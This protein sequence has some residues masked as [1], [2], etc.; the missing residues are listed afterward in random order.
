MA[1]EVLTLVG[2]RKV[3]VDATGVALFNASWPCSRLQTTRAYWFEFDESGDLID[4][5]VPEHS[6]G[7]ESVAMADDCKAWLDEGESPEWL[8]A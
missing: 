5:D 6:D 7:P 3:R 8:P 4:C 1:H 2:P